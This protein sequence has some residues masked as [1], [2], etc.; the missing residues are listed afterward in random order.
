MTQSLLDND[1]YKF[2]MQEALFKLGFSA[3]PV[4]Y[5]FHCRNE[6]FDFR[7]YFNDIQ[8]EIKKLSD[9]SLTRDESYFMK[10]MKAGTGRIFFDDYVNVLK[11]FKFNLSHLYLNLDGKNLDLRIK[12]PWFN[13]ILFEVPLLYKISE[14]C[15]NREGEDFSE[16]ERRLDK[17]L[18]LIEHVPNF[19]FGDFGTRR[20]KSLMCQYQTV[21]KCSERHPEKF[22]GT[23]NVYLAMLFKLKALGTMAHEWLQ[24]HQQLKYRVSESQKMAF[25]NWI[26]VFRGNLGIALA[27]IINTDAFLKDFDDPL[28]YKLFDGVREDSEPDPIEFGKRMIRFYSERNID[29]QSK[30]IIFSNGLNFEKA[31]KIHWELCHSIGV[32]FGIGTNLTNDYPTPALNIVIKMVKCNNQPVAKISNSPGKGMCESPEFVEYL[33]SVYNV[34]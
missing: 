7:P 5:K 13:T 34:E 4:E 14:V 16:G 2:T 6:D 32:S 11:G 19:Y 8:K 23:S 17:K 24:A 25:E 9:V 18:D 30:K 10:N 20:R 31:L 26:K 1:L 22:I 28:F 12:G 27:D 33:K 29:P 3:V 15:C 21:K